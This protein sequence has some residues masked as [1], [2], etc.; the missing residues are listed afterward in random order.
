M[1]ECTHDCSTCS[2]NCSSRKQPESF[3]ER[4]ND[5]SHVKKVIGNDGKFFNFLLKTTSAYSD[6]FNQS[7]SQNIYYC[8]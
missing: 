5:M 3:L 1:S 7:I 2:Q 6:N 4:T 8:Q